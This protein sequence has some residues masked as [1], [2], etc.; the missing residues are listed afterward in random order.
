MNEHYM[1]SLKDLLMH[2][3]ECRQ[4][5]E[6]LTQDQAY[7][8]YNSVQWKILEGLKLVVINQMNQISLD[9]FLDP[10]LYP[11]LKAL[12]VGGLQDIIGLVQFLK[13][14]QQFETLVNSVIS[15]GD[16]WD[17][18]P[19]K[20]AVKTGFRTAISYKDK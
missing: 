18:Y 4:I 17:E 2:R 8:E 7:Q 15:K 16:Q 5:L 19:I 20:N 6:L 9:S 10:R 13:S 11:D 14:D 12:T 3:K 1:S